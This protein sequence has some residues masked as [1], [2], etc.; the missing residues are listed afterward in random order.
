MSDQNMPIRPMAGGIDKLN[1]FTDELHDWSVG[2][3]KPLL[4]SKELRYVLDRQRER[5]DSKGILI[6]EKVDHTG[7][8]I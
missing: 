3:K 5:L 8:E 7:D 6:E 2:G 4:A 1:A